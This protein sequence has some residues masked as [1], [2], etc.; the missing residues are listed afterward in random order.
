MKYVLLIYQPDPFDFRSLPESEQ[1]SIGAAYAALND[2]EKVEPG[3][4][5]GLPKDALTVRVDDAKAITTAGPFV[6]AA[7]AVGGYYIVE[8]ET[9]EQA[10]EIAAR[11]PAA[12]LGGAVEVRP[13]QI[14]W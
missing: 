3:L 14:Y 11:V 13:A 4:P 12:R 1:Q 6:N 2:T 7:G 10:V 5:L 8:A 9:Q